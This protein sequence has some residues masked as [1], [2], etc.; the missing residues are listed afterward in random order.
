VSVSQEPHHGHTDCSEVLHRI[1]EYL[2]GELAPGDVTRIAAHLAECQP[3]LHEHDL[4]Q[5][6][7]AAIRRA[8]VEQAP[9][10]SLRIAIL[11]RITAVSMEFDR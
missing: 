9:P 4:D 7:G 2:D 3:C 10:A 6:V 8:C 11:T 1:Y 5:A